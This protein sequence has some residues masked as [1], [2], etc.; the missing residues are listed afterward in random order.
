MISRFSGALISLL[1]LA[2]GP[3]SARGLGYA[4]SGGGARGYAHIGILKVLEENGIH[5]DYISGTS[6]GAIIGG[7]AAMGY[8]AS[9]I[10]QLAVEFD[11][12]ELL[13]DAFDRHDI[14]IGQKRWTPYGNLKLEM[15]RDWVPRL[16]SSVFVGNGINL[17]L[18]RLYASASANRDFSTLP[19]PFSCVATDLVNGEPVVFRSGSLMQAIRA[20]VSIPS[21]VKPFEFDGRTYIDGGISQN[22]PIQ[23]VKDLGADVVLGLKVNSTLR[24]AGQLIDIIDV[25]DQSINIGITRNLNEYLQESDFLLEPSLDEF[26]ASDLRNVAEIIAA[27]EAYAR[28]RLPDILAFR[29]SLLAAGYSLSPP[30]KQPAADKYRVYAIDCQGN[31]YISCAKIREYLKLTPGRLSLDEILHACEAAWNSMAFHAIYPVLLP[32]G[33]GFRLRIYVKERQRRNLTLNL[34]YSTEE[35]LNAGGI[36]G[37][38]NLIQKNSTLLAALTLGGRTEVNLD[39]VKNFGELWGAYFRVFNYLSEKRLYLYDQDFFKTSSVKA[40]EYGLTGGVGVFANRLAVGEA[41]AYAYRTKLYRDVSASAPVDSLYLIGGFGLKL[42]H[43]SLDDYVFPRSG[44]RAFTKFNFARW[45]AVSDRIFNKFVGDLD[46]Y[47]PLAD[48]LSLRLGLNYGSCFGTNEDNSF[49]P[50]YF[51]GSSGYRG[52]ER[53]AVSSPQYKIYTLSLVVNP[54]RNLFLETGLQGL[55]LDVANEWGLD[56]EIEWSAYGELGYRTML[57]PVR[58]SVASRRNA[59]VHYYVNLGYDM[60][61]FWFS[62]K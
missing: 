30:A 59:K 1:F 40:L 44:I 52:Y 49:D 12:D 50:F 9:E 22:L 2:L 35:G 48:F 31:E 33:D 29:D 36:L 15:D 37:L 27:G 21:L 46:V 55:N 14:Y 60:D 5:P 13:A 38:N 3:L 28:S 56:Q 57:G 62:R 6:I 23:Q 8:S 24:P 41:F 61:I 58:F 26:S 25:L 45:S 20:S 10:E 54:T 39:Y 51:S 17:E 34:T 53:Y 47:A 18:F 7:L 43:E 32:E 19:V 11:W 42:Y 4:L 16:P